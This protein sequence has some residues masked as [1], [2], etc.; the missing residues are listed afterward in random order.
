MDKVQSLYTGPDSKHT[1]YLLSF[2]RRDQ[3]EN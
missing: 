1:C 3:L 2:A